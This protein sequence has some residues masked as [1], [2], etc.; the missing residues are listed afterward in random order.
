M[1]Y[2]LRYNALGTAELRHPDGYWI[3]PGLGLFRSTGAAM[4]WLCARLK[5]GAA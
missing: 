1:K 5:G 3:G 2:R 4:D